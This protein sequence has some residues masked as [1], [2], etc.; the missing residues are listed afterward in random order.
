MDETVAS[1]S[2]PMTNENLVSGS[3]SIEKSSDI[4][5]MTSLDLNHSKQRANWNEFGVN[6]EEYFSAL[7]S[8]DKLSYSFILVNYSFWFCIFYIKVYKLF[9]QNC[10]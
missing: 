8:N 1:S 4:K 6:F 9:N 5:S 7:N 2:R 10:I 3:R